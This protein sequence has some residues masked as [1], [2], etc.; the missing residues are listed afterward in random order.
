VIALSQYDDIVVRMI[1]EIRHYSIAPGR[2]ADIHTRFRTCLPPLLARHG[3][4]VV[5]RWTSNVMPEKP[6][7]VYMM[8]YRNL[9]QRERCWGGFYADPDWP[10]LRA[11]SN[12]AADM[13]ERIDITFLRHHT[14]WEPIVP[15][16]PIGGVHE[17]SVTRVAPGQAQ[18]LP[19]HVSGYGRDMLE[20][21]GGKILM[22]ADL[23]TGSDLPKIATL[24]A[25]PDREKCLLFRA[26]LAAGAT[27]KAGTGNHIGHFGQSHTGRS[28]F[29][30]LDPATDAL[31]LGRLGSR[32]DR[33]SQ[34]M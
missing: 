6:G 30:V 28:D 7:F 15:D 24:V 10:V 22:V 20:Q 21:H 14:G 31:P 9:A 1:W 25:W 27:A 8:A 23:I 5:G 26:V 33:T 12:G 29:L 34:S 18:V 13:I 32:P 17:L 11:Q 2:I 19:A 4:D 3:I 16:V